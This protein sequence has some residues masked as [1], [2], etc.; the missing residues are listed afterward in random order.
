MHKSHICSTGG[1][2]ACTCI[3]IG[4]VS[5]KNVYGVSYSGFMSNARG[6]HVHHFMHIY[7]IGPMQLYY[8]IIII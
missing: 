5:T 4:T 1:L 8:N 6:L 2:F 7:A 3:I